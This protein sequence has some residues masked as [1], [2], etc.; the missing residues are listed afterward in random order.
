MA[1]KTVTLTFFAVL[2][3]LFGIGFVLAPGAVLANSGV[4][5]SPN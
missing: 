4:E 5:N 1:K 2:S 3:V